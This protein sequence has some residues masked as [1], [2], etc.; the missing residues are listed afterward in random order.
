MFKNSYNFLG[1]GLLSNF[2]CLT[3]CIISDADGLNPGR[4]TSECL[5]VRGVKNVWAVKNIDLMKG[6]LKQ[7]KVKLML[8]FDGQLTDLQVKVWIIKC[9][10]CSSYPDLPDKQMDKN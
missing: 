4:Q 7:T 1:D 3:T 2:V 10:K 6:E 8:I 9:I 5:S